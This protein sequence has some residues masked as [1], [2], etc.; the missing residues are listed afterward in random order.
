MIFR[1]YIYSETRNVHSSQ[2][3]NIVYHFTSTYRVFKPY[4]FF[5]NNNRVQ[6]PGIFIQLS[7]H[8]NS[9]HWSC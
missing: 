2:Y 4:F 8:L 5:S 7:K 6:S 9:N 1:N 3:T